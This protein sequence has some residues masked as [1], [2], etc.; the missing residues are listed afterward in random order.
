MR[1]PTPDDETTVG[2]LIQRLAEWHA[3]PTTAFTPLEELLN[4][5]RML[6]A[7]VAFPIDHVIHQHH[8]NVKAALR[9]QYAAGEEAKSRSKPTT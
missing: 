5:S 4:E 9:R 7:T 6:I 1:A 3:N 8:Q 2:T